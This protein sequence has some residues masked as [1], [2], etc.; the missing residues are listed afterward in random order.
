MFFSTGL[1]QGKEGL[2][3]VTIFYLP[4]LRRWWLIRGPFIGTKIRIV[5]SQDVLIKTLPAPIK[6][7]RR[8]RK[9]IQS[10]LL[11]RYPDRRLLWGFKRKEDQVQV[12]IVEAPE[13]SYTWALEP[14]P[15]ALARVFLAC[16]LKDGYV[17]DIGRS[18]I[19]LVEM[20]E[21]RLSGFRCRLKGCDY[22]DQMVAQRKGL[23]PEKAETLRR[24]IGLEDEDIKHFFQTLIPSLEPKRPVLVTGGGAKTKGLSS[25]FPQNDL[26]KNPFVSEEEA[27]ALG[28]ALS[29]VLGRELPS[30]RKETELPPVVLK[31]ALVVWGLALVLGIVSQVSVN[32]L[33][34]KTLH[35]IQAQEVAVFKKYLPG[36]PVISPIRQLKTLKERWQSPK[37]STTLA[38]VLKHLPANVKIHAFSYQGGVLRFELEAPSKI[39]LEDLVQIT[40]GELKAI[41]ETPSGTKEFSLEVSHEAN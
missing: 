20:K 10:E 18:K 6:D 39:K 40:G 37:V 15:L 3:Q 29:P 35:R 41:R 16:G 9:F 34:K 36:Q 14:E 1:D 17:L 27:S 22:V 12:I 7:P 4:G 23:R 25:L 31:R 30:L 21:G 32:L 38:A 2:K 11:L 33:T 26:Q 8:L 28:A 5:P 19:T 24:E 13:E